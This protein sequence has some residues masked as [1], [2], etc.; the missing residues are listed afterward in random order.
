MN[1]VTMEEVAVEATDGVV[2]TSGS[3]S[4]LKKILVGAGVVLTVIG[5]TKGVKFVK[6]KIEEGKAKKA[7]KATEKETFHSEIFDEEVEVSDDE[8]V[9]E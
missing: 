2:T 6:G 4:V 8:E 9:S 7:K 3:G 1:N 5:I